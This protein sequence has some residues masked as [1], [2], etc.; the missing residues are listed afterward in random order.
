MAL[1]PAFLKAMSMP[2]SAAVHTRDPILHAAA[3]IDFE[4]HVRSLLATGRKNEAETLWESVFEVQHQPAP[5]APILDGTGLPPMAAMAC[6]VRGCER[7]TNRAGGFRFPWI[8]IWS[9]TGVLVQPGV[10]PQTAWT[11]W[12]QSTGH[13]DLLQ[14]QIHGSGLSRSQLLPEAWANCVARASLRPG[15][16]THE[17]VLMRWRDWQLGSEIWIDPLTSLGRPSRED[18]LINVSLRAQRALLDW[19]ASDPE[20]CLPC[21]CQSCGQATRTICQHC[22][23][24]VCRECDNNTRHNL[25][26]PCCLEMAGSNLQ[27]YSAPPFRPDDTELDVFREVVLRERST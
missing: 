3:R 24:G 14:L 12:A 15:C 22:L 19:L 16:A 6:T 9:K 25:P 18:A 10:H 23:V 26:V 1:L 4:H 20:Y 13:L 8:G 11:T 7:C 21:S 2:S 5:R 17:E 27:R